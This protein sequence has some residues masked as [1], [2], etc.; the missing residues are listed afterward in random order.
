MGG[1][2]KNSSKIL[3]KTKQLNLPTSRNSYFVEIVQI[4]GKM[5]G[6]N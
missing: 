2:N 5:K 1:L 4:F 6:W 3:E